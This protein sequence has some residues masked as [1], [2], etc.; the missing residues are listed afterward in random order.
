M[1]TL[2]DFEQSQL[3]QFLKTWCVAYE[4]FARGDIPEARRDGEQQAAQLISQLAQN[5][6]APWL[7][8]NPL[9]L[10]I[11]ALIYRQGMQL[12]AR[13]VE[14]YDIASRTLIETWNR[15]RNL[16]DNVLLNLPDP[17]LT[18]ELLSDVALWM[19]QHAVV[20][21][22]ADDLLPVLMASQEQRGHNMSEG[23]AR[24]S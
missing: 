20:A 14:L 17:R 15:A 12:P 16:S 23:G 2:R 22:R 10:T 21:A 11:I 6:G 4:Q 5:A 18:A 13:R 3:E 9:L 7:A 8:G 24:I 19:Q 1:V